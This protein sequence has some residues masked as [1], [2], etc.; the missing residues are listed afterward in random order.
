MM[1]NKRKIIRFKDIGDVRG[2]LISLEEEENIPFIIKRVYF[3]YNPNT[4]MSRGFH[5][6]KKLEQVVVCLKGKCRFI[7]DDGIERISYELN[8]PTEGLYIGNNEWREMHDFSDDC[9]LAVIASEKY[10]ESDY[11]RDY[12]TFKSNV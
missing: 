12:K 7:L 4:E 11:I 6:H 5:A 1:M 8:K 3:L 10:D 2:G 9:V